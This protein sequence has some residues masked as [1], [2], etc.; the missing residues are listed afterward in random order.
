MTE[1]GYVYILSA[2][3]IKLPLSKI[4]MT[5]RAPQ[6]RCAEINKS[7]T[8]DLLWQVE[9]QVF[10]DDCQKAESLLH[11]KLAKFR[12]TGR[13]FFNIEPNVANEELLLLLQQSS[14]INEL[15]APSILPI[16]NINNVDQT[17][18]ENAAN[19]CS[20][21]HEE[22]EELYQA[23]KDRLG[24]EGKLFGQAGKGIVGISDNNEGIQWN[25]AIYQDSGDVAL[26]VNLEGKKY[27]NWPIAQF[28]SC[29]LA[30]P[31]IE[32]LQVT[33]FNAGLIRVGFFRDAWQVAS[34]P[35]IMEY[36]LKNSETLLS[37]W[38][39]G[40]WRETLIE[41]QACLCLNNF[42]RGRGEQEVSII[43]KGGKVERKLM[44]ISPHLNI[45]TTAFNLADEGFQNVQVKL[46]GAFQR[47]T[48][49]YSWV[50]QRSS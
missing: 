13:E 12:Q 38:N 50:A 41:A 31:T 24:V 8:G 43:R 18:K 44:P 28:I 40:L 3:D 26:G 10:V 20:V 1:N 46:D 11:K 19:P 21:Q 33:E 27:D 35:K 48:D 14:L 49:I 36:H 2:K 37:D 25:L 6:V 16:I 30:K 29:E 34:R 15:S 9:H 4:G 17:K 39:F 42:H 32:F 7:S 23:F 5:T 45:R 22:A 47:L